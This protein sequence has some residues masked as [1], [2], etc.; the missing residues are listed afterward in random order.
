MALACDA[1]RDGS[2]F[3]LDAAVIDDQVDLVRVYP[4]R[5]DGAFKTAK[6]FVSQTTPVHLIHGDWDGDPYPDVATLNVDSGDIQVFVGSSTQTFTQSD[7]IST[8]SAVTITSADLDEDEH[9]DLSWARWT[10]A[11]WRSRTAMATARSRP[12]RP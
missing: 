3:H 6:A 2:S 1:P 10:R 9:A 5:G 4:G 7:T 12:R 8:V 11:S